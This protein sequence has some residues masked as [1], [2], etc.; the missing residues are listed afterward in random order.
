MEPLKNV[1]RLTKVES[2][3]YSLIIYS[4]IVENFSVALILQDGHTLGL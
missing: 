2:T 1:S 3:L 4:T